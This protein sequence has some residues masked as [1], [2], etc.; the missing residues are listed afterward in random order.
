MSFDTLILSAGRS[1]RMGQPKALLLY[2][3]KTLLEHIV[4]T[5]GQ[6]TPGK[7][8]LVCGHADA[9]STL[10]R[11]TALE[12]TY[13]IWSSLIIVEGK[14]DAHPIDSIRCGIGALPTHNRLLLW[15]VDMVF[16]SIELVG[17]LSTSFQ[18]NDDKIARPIFNGQ[19]GHP[20]LFGREARQQLTT[21]MAD[22]GAHRIVHHNPGRLI[23]I[24]CNDERI[25]QAMNTPQEAR[26]RGLSL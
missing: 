2:H 8:V 9:G 3:G 6:A 25:T 17:E 12:L 1:R 18:E 23:D 24:P 4:D 20:V 15:P 5:A 22:E 16:G 7:V 26:L 13:P 14:S 10:T 21:A 11:K 19:H